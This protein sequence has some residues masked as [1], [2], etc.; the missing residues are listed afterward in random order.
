[1]K[2]S[3]HFDSDEFDSPDLPGS[4]KKMNIEFILMLELARQ[5]AD[6]PFIINSGFRTIEHN[7]KVGG[8]SK[9]SHLKGLACDI[10]CVNPDDRYIIINALTMAGFDRIGIAKTFIHVDIDNS[11]PTPSI[12]LY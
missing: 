2:L 5:L 4:G 9:S 6:I 3:K 8:I 10:H 11:K 12:F 1:M 7:K